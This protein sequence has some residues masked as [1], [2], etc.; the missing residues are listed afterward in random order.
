MSSRHLSFLETGRSQPSRE[1]VLRLG[2]VLDLPLRNRNELLLSAGF[3]SQFTEQGLD[4][5]AMAEVMAVL[6]IMAT[7]D[8]D[9]DHDVDGDA[10]D[11]DG[12]AGAGWCC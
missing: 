1:M 6:M 2:Q 7:T 11:D 12:G 3:A 10:G 4:Q 8:D 9:G 5:S